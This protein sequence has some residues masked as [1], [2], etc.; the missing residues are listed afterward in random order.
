MNEK[1][2]M[3]F[4]TRPEAIKMCPVVLALKKIPQLK[5]VVCVT[6]QHK[7]M[8]NQ[9]LERFSIVPDYDF[10]IMRQSQT[11]DEITSRILKYLT[12]ALER[13]DPDIVMVHGDTTTAFASALASFY[14]GIPVWHV[15]AGLRTYNLDSPFPEELNRQA[16]DLIASKYF[17]PTENAKNNLIAEGKNENAIVVTGNTGIDSLSYMVQ[18]DFRCALLN[19]VKNKKII[20]LTTHR[21]ENI[22][23]AMMNIFRAV[24]RIADEFEDIFVIYPVHLNP[25]VKDIAEKTLSGHPRIALT[26]PMDV[27]RFQN[28]LARSTF[29][30]TDSGGIQEEANALQIPVLVVRDTTERPEGI[31][32]G[33]LKLAG[34]DE[35][36]IY[37]ECRRLLTDKEE[38]KK[39]S[40]AVNPF[41]D[42]CASARIAQAVRSYFGYPEEMGGVPQYDALG[43]LNPRVQL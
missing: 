39:M 22:G 43:S 38:Y 20:L 15:E 18:K 1:V 9:V 33:G 2:M 14:K 7:E 31:V 29:V 6:G 32:S 17:A 12:S 36:G 13:V 23:D 11:L 26:P 8:L 37:E 24:R 40:S 35:T 25:A 27:Y 3:I 42:G 10:A 4:G 21:R 34:T 41:G 28:I 19:R 16:V 30:L 5:T